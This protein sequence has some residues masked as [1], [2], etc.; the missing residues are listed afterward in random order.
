MRNHSTRLLSFL[1]RLDGLQLLG[2]GRVHFG[3]TPL[4]VLLGEVLEGEGGLLLLRLE[5]VEGG[6]VARLGGGEPLCE[7]AVSGQAKECQRKWRR[8]WVRTMS[9]TTIVALPH[10]GE[11]RANGRDGGTR[12]EADNNMQVCKMLSHP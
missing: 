9:T 4:G 2:E 7:Q 11:F 8:G 1:A 10:F 5:R 12:K 3:R 6:A